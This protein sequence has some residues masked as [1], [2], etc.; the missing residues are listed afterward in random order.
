MLVCMLYVFVILNPVLFVKIITQICLT[1][2]S[3]GGGVGVG[4]PFIVSHVACEDLP[5][6][7]KKQN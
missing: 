5:Y 3:S 2:I 1:S 4:I 7:P 6:L